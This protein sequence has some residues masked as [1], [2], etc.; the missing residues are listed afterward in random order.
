YVLFLISIT[1]LTDTGAYLVGSMIG[2][3]KAV[4]H[5]SPAKTWQ[6][7]GGALIFALIAAFGC[8]YLFGNKIPL[9]TPLHAGVL[10][11][12][13]AVAAVIGDLG[14]SIIKRS[15]EVKDSSKAMPGI[16]GVMDLIDSVLMTGPVFYLYLLFLAN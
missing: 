14:E 4:P 1:K 16:G 8:L 12:L 10:A 6:G 2:K 13:L 5:I 11:V 7:F 15:L 3:H 9:I